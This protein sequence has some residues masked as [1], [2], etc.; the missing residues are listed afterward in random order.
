ME[1]YQLQAGH[2]RGACLRLC[3][4]SVI[5]QGQPCRANGRTCQKDRIANRGKEERLRVKDLGCQGDFLDLAIVCLIPS[6]LCYGTT[7]RDCEYNIKK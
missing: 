4:L 3:L 5:C 6:H 7:R 1:L 2:V